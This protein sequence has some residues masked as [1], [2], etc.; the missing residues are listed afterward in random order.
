MPECRAFAQK[1]IH[2]TPK[3]SN[4]PLFPSLAFRTPRTPTARSSQSTWP[5]RKSI[6][7]AV[8][9]AIESP[10]QSAFRRRLL[11]RHGALASCMRTSH[12]EPNVSYKVGQRQIQSCVGARPHQSRLEE[13]CHPSPAKATTHRTRQ[14]GRVGP[15]SSLD[16]TQLSRRHRCLPP[17]D[18]RP[19]CIL[20]HWDPAAIPRRQLTGA[21]HAG[22]RSTL[23]FHR[24]QEGRR[25]RHLVPPPLCCALK[26]YTRQ[27]TEGGTPYRSRC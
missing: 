24:I 1:N 8:L 9:L 21:E 12:L 17:A 3:M 5:K 23:N 25:H 2:T 14:V 20:L 4:Y 18:H 6:T 16:Q 22:A 11:R 13:I 26:P 15:R 27:M 10:M 19:Y 7:T